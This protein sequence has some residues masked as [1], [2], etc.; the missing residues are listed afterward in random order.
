VPASSFLAQAI[1][2]TARHPD[3]L[4]YPPGRRTF[5]RHRHAWWRPGHRVFLHPEPATGC[6]VSCKARSRYSKR[7]SQT[8]KFDLSSS[9]NHLCTR[10]RLNQA[11]LFELIP[12][13]IAAS[14]SQPNQ[15]SRLGSDLP[16][17]QDRAAIDRSFYAPFL[18]YDAEVPSNVRRLNKGQRSASSTSRPQRGGPTRKR[19]KRHLS[20]LNGQVVVRARTN[21]LAL[22]SRAI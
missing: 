14:P 1:G 20:G 19:T 7:P 13:R 22:K 9:T 8:D 10:I 3:R 2:W 4:R 16:K 11:S 12:R 17:G 15:P 5:V 21:E 18:E 6:T